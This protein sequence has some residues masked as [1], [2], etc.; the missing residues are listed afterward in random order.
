[1]IFEAIYFVGYI[2][3]FIINNN[4]NLH[5][6]GYSLDY[7]FYVVFVILAFLFAC[8]Y[9]LYGAVSIALIVTRANS[10]HVLYIG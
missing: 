3:L 6:E 5:M 1:L 2:V 9:L 10:D 7:E 8:F 4:N